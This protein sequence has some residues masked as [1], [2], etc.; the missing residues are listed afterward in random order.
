M[1][2]EMSQGERDGHGAEPGEAHENWV[3]INLKIISYTVLFGPN[4]KQVVFLSPPHIP[5]PGCPIRS[6]RIK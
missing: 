6:L 3:S 1:I 2:M 5:I 4:Y